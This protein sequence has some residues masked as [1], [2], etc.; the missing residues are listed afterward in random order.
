MKRNVFTLHVAFMPESNRHNQILPQFVCF[1]GEH[2]QRC[3]TKLMHEYLAFS[4]LFPWP[5]LPRAHAEAVAIRPT[6]YMTGL[7]SH[8]PPDVI[9]IIGD[10]GTQG[11]VKMKREYPGSIV[12]W[13]RYTDADQRDVELRA[14]TANGVLTC[15][16]LSAMALREKVHVLLFEKFDVT[17]SNV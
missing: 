17:F 9:V 15:H 8:D 1:K 6:L 4:A 14:L 7:G 3:I 12:L 5:R 11:P 10:E 13:S 16:D 2:E